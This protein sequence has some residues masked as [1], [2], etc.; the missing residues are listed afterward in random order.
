MDLN[1]KFQNDY[2]N[3][4]GKKRFENKHVRM[5]YDKKNIVFGPPVSEAEGVINPYGYNDTYHAPAGG[6]RSFIEKKNKKNEITLK[7]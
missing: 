5:E 2:F 4:S 7:P 6:S 1:Y 3:F